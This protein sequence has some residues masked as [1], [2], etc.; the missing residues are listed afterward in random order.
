MHAIC[1][2]ARAWQPHACDMQQRQGIAATCMRQAAVPGHCSHKHA[3]CSSAR[4]LQP[5]ECTSQQGNLIQ[6]APGSVSGCHFLQVLLPILRQG[7]DCHGQRT[8]C[9]EVHSARGDL[10][11]VQTVVFWAAV[12]V[13]R[14]P[15]TSC[16]HYSA[17]M[18]IE[19]MPE[20]D[21][22]QD[23]LLALTGGRSVPRVFVN[24]KFIGASPIKLL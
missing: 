15:S 9:G 19:K 12:Y 8:T 16:H 4:A 11:V 20:C 22:I 21:A 24:G 14:Q 3:I 23:A 6:P 17:S 13:H 2:S 7:Q 10:C 1:S 5:H 18:Q